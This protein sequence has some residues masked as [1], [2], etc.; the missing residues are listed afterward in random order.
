MSRK[1][2]RSQRVSLYER[3]NTACPI[4]LRV[5][6]RDQAHSGRAV[7][8]EHVPIRALGGQ[9]R[10]LTFKDCNAQAGQGIDQA[11]A[12]TTHDRFGVTVDI[13]GKRRTFMLSRDGKELSPPFKGFSREDW[14]DLENTE[15]RSFT[16]SIRV[17]DGKAVAA[18]SLKSAYLAVFSLLG[19]SGGDSYIRGDALK[20]VRLLM[21]PL[22]DDAIGGYVM[23]APDNASLQDIMLVSEPLS[24]WMLKIADHLVFLPLSGDSWTSEPLKELQR[25]SPGEP[26]GIVGLASWPFSTFGE[27]GTVP[28]HLA[29][30]DT[31]KSLVGGRISDTLPNG[32]RLEGTCVGHLGESA[33]LLCSAPCSAAQG[34]RR[35]S[36]GPSGFNQRGQV[37]NRVA[38]SGHRRQDWS[39]SICCLA[40]SACLVL[41]SHILAEVS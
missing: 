14:R 29:G 23:K 24:C 32:R 28:V 35:L 16:M 37:L 27:F 30:A 41:Q 34:R 7:T 4:C 25:L 2:G 22:K 10:C 17:P 8:L 1:T 40:S 38:T 12:M 6:T 39:F 18:S 31:A 36:A 5:F 20:A 19:P 9:A 13:L 15:S 3:G 26:V 21:E 33:T 11:A